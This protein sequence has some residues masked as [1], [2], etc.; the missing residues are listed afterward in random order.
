MGVGDALVPQRVELHHRDVGGRQPRQ[1]EDPGAGGGGVRGDPGGAPH[2]APQVGLPTQPGVA[3]VPHGSV[4]EQ[5]R[6]GGAE[7]VV[8]RRAAQVLEADR[9]SAPIA[10][11]QGDPGGQ[12]APGA[13]APHG[14]PVGPDAPLGGVLRQPAQPGVT[15]LQGRGEGVLGR[16]AVVDRDHQR[17]QLPA[18]HQVPV[19]VDVRRTQH[20]AAAVDAVDGRQRPLGPKRPVEPQRDVGGALRSGHAD[21]GDVHP[22][23]V[24][25]GDPRGQLPRLRDPCRLDV[26]DVDLGHQ[27][28]RRGQFG[29][30]PVAHVRPPVAVVGVGGDGTCGDVRDVGDIGDAVVRR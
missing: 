24:R 5:P 9:G 19:V 1:F 14:D 12:G 30:E 20:E 22:R 7:P 25:R 10:G 23:G 8:E 21:L 13:V 3:P 6:A 28:E 11:E 17:L 4:G 27:R 18:Q 15:V 29:V 2:P 26:G 16:Q